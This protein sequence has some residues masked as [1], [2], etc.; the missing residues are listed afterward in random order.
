MKKADNTHSTGRLLNGEREGKGELTHISILDPELENK[1][2]NMVI[3][4]HIEPE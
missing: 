1:M 2:K 3:H 4:I